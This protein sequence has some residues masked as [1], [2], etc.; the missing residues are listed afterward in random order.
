M[1]R[2][3]VA[4]AM[5]G[6]DENL[7]ASAAT[8]RK[9]F[10]PFRTKG[11][12]AGLSAVAAAL[13]IVFGA[14]VALR[15]N[16]EGGGNIDGSV[17][18]SGITV[19]ALDV[20]P[21]IEID[22]DSSGIVEEVEALNSEAIEVIG[23]RSFEN[24]DLNTTIKVLVTSMVEQGYLSADKNS[25]LISVDAED[26]SFETELQSNISANISGLLSDKSISASLITQG[27]DK[28]QNAEGGVS[29]AKTALINKIIKAGLLHS[30]GTPYTKEQ[31]A[32]LNINELKLILESKNV[33]VEGMTASGTASESGYIGRDAAI[34]I[35]ADKAGILIENIR[36]IE[37]E[38]DYDD[39]MHLMLYEV[40]FEYLDNEYE[41][42]IDAKT[43]E[44]KSEETEPK[45]EDDENIDPPA[46][47]IGKDLAI[48]IALD[49]MGVSAS[50][51]YDLECELEREG[52]SY[53]YEVEFEIGEY[54][55]EYK[56][57]AVT[58]DIISQ[59]KE[60]EN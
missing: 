7:I 22:V 39:E 1:K 32:A 33:T 23:G 50:D 9:V 53:I 47:A 17:L 36:S 20:N 58:G 6:L 59:N 40:E 15:G 43:G 37:I 48:G 35:A 13:L 31:L 8:D 45:G 21:S 44:I 41:Y 16:P 51:V 4:R 10:S 26:D 34:G 57:N 54:K 49:N 18:P 24:T 14:V 25:L 38:L 12:L 60:K 30:G 29:R 56:I 3:K 55:Y 11:M 46:D 5:D 2:N 52:A 42:E 27:F 28:N 19:V